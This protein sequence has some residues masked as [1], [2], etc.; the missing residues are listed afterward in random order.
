MVDILKDTTQPARS[1][2]FGSFTNID[3][4]ALLKTGTTDNLKDVYAVG[5][6][7]T[8]V[9]GVWMGNS[10]GDLMSAKDFSSAIGPGQLR[11]EEHTSELQSLAY[12]VCRLLLE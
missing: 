10:N 6:T 2:I 12:L 11:S 7:P 9:T 4:P 1:P 3:R 5:A 8:L